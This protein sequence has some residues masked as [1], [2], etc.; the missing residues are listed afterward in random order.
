MTDT[1]FSIVITTA[2]CLWI[3]SEEIKGVIGIL[4]IKLAQWLTANN[5]NRFR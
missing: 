3:F 4:K 1:T 2:L 5:G